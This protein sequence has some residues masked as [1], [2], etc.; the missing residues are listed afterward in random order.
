MQEFRKHSGQRNTLVGG[1][2]EGEGGALGFHD[3]KVKL[4]SGKM[5]RT[6]RTHPLG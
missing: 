2:G 5:S 6:L 3:E 4:C 1:R